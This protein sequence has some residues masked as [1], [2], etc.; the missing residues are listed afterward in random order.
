M[1]QD[2]PIIQDGILTDLRD[3]S[4]VQIV[5]GSADW[6]AWLQT[7][8]T[9]TF[10]GKQ[11][12][13]SAHRERAGHRR[14]SAY[15]RAYRTWHGK[16]HRAYL[17]QSEEL[18]LER[19]QS[20]AVVLASKGAGDGSLDMPAPRAGTNSAAPSSPRARSHRRQATAAPGP[21]EA[22]HSAPLLANLPVPLTPLIG[23]EEEVQAIG[24]LL[25]RP[26]V[27]L[28]TITGTGGVGK[29]RLAVEVARAVRAD[30]ADGVCFVALAGTLDPTRVIPVIAQELGLWEAADHPPLEQVQ[31]YLREKHLLL[32]LDNFEQV[33]AA[34]PLLARL[35]TSCPR[36]SM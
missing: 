1:A 20:V 12:S 36:L 21:H 4:F 24:E 28:L 13:F 10:R 17:G 18:T 16:L 9:F 3:G 31:D 30:F 34:A 23:R 33:L 29:T 22:A 5:V 11:G 26:E 15:W 35:L 19:L 2:S 32:L 8:S 27:R 25:G 14:G 7:A 6:Y